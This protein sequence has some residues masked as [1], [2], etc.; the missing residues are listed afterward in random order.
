[1][2]KK[3]LTILGGISLLASVGHA[4][5]ITVVDPVLAGIGPTTFSYAANLD[6]G[7]V[8]VGN[9][10]IVIYDFDGYVAGSI[11]APAGWTSTISL[12]GVPGSPG[13]DD[14]LI[15]NLNFNYTAG[16]TVTD[17]LGAG[18]TFLGLFG[19]KSTLSGSYLPADLDY[20]TRDRALNGGASGATGTVRLPA[21]A[22]PDSGS[23]VALLGLALGGIQVLRRKFTIA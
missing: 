1:M 7:Q 4:N 3:Y 19:A 11:F 15:P 8:I 9:G 5:T 22:V 14:P 17:P 18:S 12:S 6:N 13:I 10:R 2:K 20:S 23:T 21:K 16:P